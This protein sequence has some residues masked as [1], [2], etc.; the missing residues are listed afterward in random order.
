MTADLQRRHPSTRRARLSVPGSYLPGA[1]M[2]PEP[3]AAFALRAVAA[4]FIEEPVRGTH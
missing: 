2:R 3:T 4:F 1:L